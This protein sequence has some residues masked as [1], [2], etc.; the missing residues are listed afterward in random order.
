MAAMVEELALEVVD[1]S[2][3]AA[4]GAA[5]SETVEGSG[6]TV[7]GVAVAAGIAVR[8]ESVSRLSL[9]RSAAMS[10]AVW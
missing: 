5:A 10:A 2:E 4:G 9:R 1:E 8:L 3:T 7:G 6:A